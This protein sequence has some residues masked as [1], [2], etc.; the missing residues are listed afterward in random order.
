MSRDDRE[1]PDP[2][3]ARAASGRSGLPAVA[4]VAVV[5]LLVLGV[6]GGLGARFFRTERDTRRAEVDARAELEAAAVAGAQQR[7]AADGAMPYRFGRGVSAEGIKFELNSNK[8]YLPV[9]VNGGDERWFIL[10]SGCPITSIDM[11]V[12]RELDLPV[13]NER[14]VG[15]AGEGRTTVADTAL[16]MLSL[17]GL[18]LFPRRPW[19]IG[20]SDR[21][22]PF[23]GRRI[24]GLLGLDFLEQFAVRID[25][26]NRTL[27]VLRAPDYKPGPEDVAVPL[28]LTGSHY[29]AAATLKAKDGRT[30]A[31]RFVFDI[32]V[33]QPLIVSTPFVDKHGLV[34]ALKAGPTQTV[35]GGLGGET[36]GQLARLE[37]LKIGDLTVDAPVVALS[38][39]KRGFL[40]NPETDGLLGAEVFRRYVLTFDLQ[41]RR[42]V[43][44]KTAESQRPY[45]TD[46][47][48]LFLTADGP[49]YKRVKVLSVVEGGP[50]AEAGV[51]AGDELVEVDGKPAAGA[52]LEKLREQ[53]R[54]AGAT[55]A[56]KLRRQDKTLD[57]TVRLRRLV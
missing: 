14:P 29:T 37:S 47:G 3:H 35:G 10:D 34:A 48:G 20:V 21:V 39:E 42:V 28:E 54:Q 57:V 43:F 19:A 53:F 22:G 4:G 23:E 9:R 50:A 33:R 1:A 31:G 5:G 16:Q 11:T 2:R 55:R 15:G 6:A 8:V 32:G 51:R 25:Y 13:R 56:L 41:N 24:D 27:D 12:A 30:F 52:T 45:E 7:A 46:A 18:D 49:D 38:Q 17:P 26:P 36:R 44:T 40:A